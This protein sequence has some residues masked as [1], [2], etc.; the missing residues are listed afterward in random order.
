M[1]INKSVNIVD[2]SNIEKHKFL[3]FILMFTNELHI[4]K[5][6]NYFMRVKITF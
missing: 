5:F 3:V 2:Y 1:F 4:L 6:K